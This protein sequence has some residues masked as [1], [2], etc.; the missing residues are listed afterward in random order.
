MKNTDYFVDIQSFYTNESDRTVEKLAS[1]YTNIVYLKEIILGLFKRHFA[2]EMICNKKVLLKPNWVKHS[3]VTYDEICLR[4]NDNV[5]LATLETV[6][7]YKPLL[8]VIG[9]APVQGCNWD[10]M[11]SSSLLKSIDILSEQY[12]IVVKVKDFRRVTFNPSKNISEHNRK[13]LSEYNIFDL[14]VDSYLEP[15]SRSD[16]NVFRVTN[17]NPDRLSESHSMGVHKYCISKELF[18]TDLIISL[19]KVKTH[20]KAGITAALK[21]LVGLNGDKDYL[22]HHRIGG[23]G[24]GGDCYPGKNRLRLLSEQLLDFANR[25]QGKFSYWVGLRLSVIL[26]RFTFPK[27]VHQLAA[28]W[29]GNDTTWR[30]VL[31]LNKIAMY[32]KAD[33][34][35]AKN[36]QRLIYSLCDGIIG[37]Q[38][39]GPLQPE[40]LGLGILSLTNHSGLNDLIMGLLMGFQIEKIPLLNSV[41][42]KLDLK[43]TTILWNNQKIN[44]SNIE[45]NSIHTEPPP[46]WAQFLKK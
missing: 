19:P 2:Y 20:Q 41:K 39:N 27:P 43:N 7:Q 16:K 10:R 14:G 9:D 4:T 36:P 34:T 38:G 1:Q 28:G 8:V 31:D 37:G 18:E 6:L 13:P 11:L 46:G 29:Y 32:G 15:I 35:I 25:R 45:L 23:T 17:Y 26:W 21:N 5:L 42:D 30:M 12:N 44:L 22:P 40:P 24:F 33:G 3:T